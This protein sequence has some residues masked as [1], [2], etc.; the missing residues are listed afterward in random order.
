MSEEIACGALHAISGQRRKPNGECNLER[1]LQ[2]LSVAILWA[3][4]L[5][6]LRRSSESAAICAATPSR[7]SNELD[8]GNRGFVVLFLFCLFVS[9]RCLLGVDLY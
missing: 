7:G 5:A 9:P 6:A 2:Y 1:H 8:R 3:V 4:A